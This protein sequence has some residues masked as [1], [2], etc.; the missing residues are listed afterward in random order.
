LWLLITSGFRTY[1]FLPVFWRWFVPR[2]DGAADCGLRDRLAAARFGAGFD[3]ATGIVRLAAPQRLRAG[4][5]EVPSGRERDPHTAFFL[6]ANPGWAAGDELACLCEL[7]DD[8][9]TP[10]G[11]RMVDSVWRA[12]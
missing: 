4:F 9:L 12:N 7:A 1:R 5:R 11:R 8:N 3:P 2:H 6:E 10:A